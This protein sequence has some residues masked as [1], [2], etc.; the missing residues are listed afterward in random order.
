MEIPDGDILKSYLT[1]G[2]L[3]ERC[4]EKSHRKCFL[5][6]YFGFFTGNECPGCGSGDSLC[7]ECLTCKGVIGVSGERDCFSIKLFCENGKIYFPKDFTRS[8][9]LGRFLGNFFIALSFGLLT[10]LIFRLYCLIIDVQFNAI[11]FMHFMSLFLLI[12]FLFNDQHSGK[13]KLVGVLLIVI[14]G[15]LLGFLFYGLGY[16]VSFSLVYL[17]FFY[18]KIGEKI[19]IDQIQNIKAFDFF[20]EKLSGTFFLFIRIRKI[21]QFVTNQIVSFLESKKLV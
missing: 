4:S 7:L 16:W 10:D 18:S 13:N 9:K 11:L 1:D 21:I 6:G 5:C 17:G 3:R 14:I 20:Y 12:I 19:Y 15:F 2:R 8:T